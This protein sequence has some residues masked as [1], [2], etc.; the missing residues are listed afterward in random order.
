MAQR[1]KCLPET[2]EIQVWSLG[3]EDPLEKEVAA[4][5][6][7]LAWKFPWT[8]EPGRLQSMGSQ[9]VGHDW[10][11]SFISFVCSVRYLQIVTV[12]LCPF[13]FGCLLFI[14]RTQFLCLIG[15]L[16]LC[17][18]KLV[19]MGFLV[20]VL[21]IEE[22]LLAFNHQICY[23]L[24]S[25]HIWPLL[26]SYIPFKPTLLRYFIM[27]RYWILSNTFFC[28]CWDGNLIFVLHFVVY[29]ID[30]WTLNHPLILWINPIW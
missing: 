27:N 21:I 28:I 8:E 10:A 17:W 11:T 5:S 24:W 18:I 22:K 15:L 26:G 16:I 13:Q 9:R 23:Q 19:R 3:Q 2:Q 4:H 7:T 25:C 6:S 12:L 20:L 14:F 30:L 1:V 29:H